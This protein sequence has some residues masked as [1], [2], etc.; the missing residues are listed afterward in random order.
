MIET[1]S[2]IATAIVVIILSQVLSKY[3]AANLIAATVLVAIAFIY[4]GFSLKDNPAG[5]VIVET[6]AA[7]VFYFLAIIG[8][9]RNGS[10]LAYGI[11][12][13]GMWDL[14]HHKG[15]VLKTDVPRYWP[16][17]CLIVDVVDGLYFLA[18][19]KSRIS[20]KPFFKTKSVKSFAKR[21]HL[22]SGI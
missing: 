6:G 20:G 19:F 13:H 16:S 7:L 5:L 3:F 15:L 10:L 22:T 1:A 17:F 8:F 21:F 11:I 14:F 9:T 2:G 4:V 18:L 12:L